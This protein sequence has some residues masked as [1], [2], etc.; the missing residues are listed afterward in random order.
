MKKDSIISDDIPF[1]YN[2]QGTGD[3]WFLS[4]K[5][6]DQPR[7][8]VW[9]KN[10][11]WLSVHSAVKAVTHTKVKGLSIF[12]GGGGLDRGLE[13]SGGVHFEHVVDQDASAIHTQ[14][15]NSQDPAQT[16]YYCG[17]VDDYL[18]STLA[19]RCNDLVAK[20]GEV[21]LLAAGCP[22]QGTLTAYSNSFVSN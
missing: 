11:V 13:E 14:R 16:H 12:S 20:V 2:R 3:H 9:L 15:A 4:M 5:L 17:S 7:R 19:G 18:S 21:D 10:S 6:M 1:P 8:L 22:C